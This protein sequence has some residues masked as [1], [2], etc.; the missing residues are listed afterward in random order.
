MASKNSSQDFVPIKEIRDGTV[1][2]EDGTLSMVLMVTS[3]NFALKSYEEQVA[4]ISQFQNFLNSLDFSIQIV[5]QSR[6]LDIRP[7]IASLDERRREQDND[8]IKIQVTEY[9]DFIRNFTEKVNIM[10]KDFFLVVSFTPALL[11]AKRSSG[12]L[13]KLMGGDGKDQITDDEVFA[14][15]KSQLEQRTDL[16]VSGISRTGLRLIRLGSEETIEVLYRIFNP[17]ESEKPVSMNQTMNK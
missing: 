1:V 2:M 14:E 10:K 15:A 16:I 13:S 6:R 11:N 3:L 17:G 9:M 5:V 7:Y 4:T 8:L 12:P